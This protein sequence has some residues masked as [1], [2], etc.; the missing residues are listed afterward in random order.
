MT[1]EVYAEPSEEPVTL[2][3]AKAHLRVTS[4]DDNDYIES[5]IRA[6]RER[7]ESYLRRS[8]CTQ[9][10][11]Y[12][13]DEFPAEI[14]L[15]RAPVQ[16]VTSITYTDTDGVS[17][18]LSA[19]LYQTNLRG[20]ANGR[21]KPTVDDAWP[22]TKSGVY[23]AVIVRYVAGYSLPSD[24]PDSIP[25]AFKQA[26]LLMVGEMYEN[27]EISV[28]G[29]TVASLPYTAEKLLAPYRLRLV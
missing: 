14:D 17:Q 6:S 2:T 19:S 18:T 13:L 22:S 15:P 16:S 1:I 3:E 8:I 21:I 11:E 10:L 28:V 27:R 29:A 26:I 24:S 9:T 12:S 5:L 4:T 25:R 7:A 23:N 20:T